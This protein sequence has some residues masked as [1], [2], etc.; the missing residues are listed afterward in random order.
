VCHAPDDGMAE[1]AQYCGH[2]PAIEVTE[3]P[4]IVA[5]E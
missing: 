1:S 2:I 3:Y 4:Y 5:Q